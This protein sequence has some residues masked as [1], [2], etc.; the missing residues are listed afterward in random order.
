MVN[1]VAPSDLLAKVLSFFIKTYEYTTFCDC[2][3]FECTYK[4]IVYDSSIAPVYISVAV[5]IS[6]KY[7]ML[8][9]VEKTHIFIWYE[10]MVN[11]RQ[12]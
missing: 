4:C 12:T 1:A 3:K 2:V 7:S 11:K 10:R 5:E 8:L 9:N 6:V